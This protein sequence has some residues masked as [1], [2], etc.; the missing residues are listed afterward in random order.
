VLPPPRQHGH[1]KYNV[2]NRA[3]RA[4]MDLWAVRWMQSRQLRYEVVEPETGA[5]GS[6]G[7]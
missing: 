6:R 7:E 3:W 1:S 2:R 4:L 5:S